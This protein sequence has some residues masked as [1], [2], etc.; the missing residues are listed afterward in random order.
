NLRKTRFFVCPAC[1]N[2]ILATDEADICCCGQ[3]LKPLKAQKPDAEHTLT[4]EKNDGEWYITAAHPMQR[5]H[6]IAFV[7]LL[8]GD[9]LTIKRLYPE[10]NLEA[11]LPYLAHGTF[12]WYC[13]RDGLFYQHI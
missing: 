12:L 4:I 1:G 7:A 6:A 11:R 3:R 8:N 2:L 13:T 5:E 9:T 10:W